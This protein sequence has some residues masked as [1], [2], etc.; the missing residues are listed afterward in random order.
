MRALPGVLALLLTVAAGAEPQPIWRASALAVRHAD[1]ALMPEGTPPNYAAFAPVRPTLVVWGEEGLPVLQGGEQAAERLRGNFAAYRRLGIRESATNLWLLTATERYLHEHPGLGEASC[2][3]LWGER[4]VPRWLSDADYKGTKPW[5]G[6]TNQPR[7]QEHLLARLRA[8][9]AAGATL[10]HLD[11]HAGTYA[12]ATGAGGCFCAECMRGFRAWLVREQTRVPGGRVAADLRAAGIE[13]LERFDYA[14]FLRPGWESGRAARGPQGDGSSTD[15]EAF[16]KE[17]WAGRVPLWSWFLAYQRE[18]ALGFVGRIRSEAATAI[19]REVAVGVNAY[20]LD[21]KQLF[22]AA[23]IDYFANEVEHWE[24]ED[25]IAPM[26]Y[27]LGD[28]LGRPVFATGTGEDW[29]S[30][31]KAGATHR[32]R[33]WIA[34]AYAFGHYFMYAWNKWGYS[35]ESGTLWT[36]IPTAVYEPFT[37]FVR[38]HPELFDGMESAATVGLL[39]D[40]AAAGSGKWQVRETSKAL[41]DAGV[42]YRLVVRGD[43]VLRFPDEAPR[44]A[45]DILV[46]PPDVAR[47]PELEAWLKAWQ[48]QAGRL[49]SQDEPAKAGVAESAGD[50]RLAAAAIRVKA[51][52]RV[53]ALPRLRAE[54]KPSTGG[55]RGVIHLLNREYPA[56]GD[57]FRRLAR[58][59]VRFPATALGGIKPGSAAYYAPGKPAVKVALNADA[60]GAFTVVVPEL[61]IWGVI[62]LE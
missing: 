51:G 23:E 36:Q 55:P 26:V 14:G 6:C 5:W 10:V 41:L 29:I 15:R 62:A 45:R 28:A 32:V 39:Y 42:P 27:R 7:Y 58:V 35:D 34:Q 3:D 61:E 16:I 33:G 11:D 13:D 31:R 2:V 22:D 47:T 43:E 12:C 25:L 18:A 24:Q 9:L 53:W 44:A 49:R 38:D 52:G 50:S 57:S 1:V 48:S 17:A 20:N 37:G 40:N 60:S 30:Y 4:I 54:P 8:G 59:E 46:V 19:R 56:S 21:P